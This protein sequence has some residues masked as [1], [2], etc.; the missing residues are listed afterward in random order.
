MG[1]DSTRYVIQIRSR[2]EQHWRHWMSFHDLSEARSM[3]FRVR[4]KGL[5]DNFRLVS[6][7]TTIEERVIG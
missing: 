5:E 2:G 7:R 3:L 6:H 1:D 4:T